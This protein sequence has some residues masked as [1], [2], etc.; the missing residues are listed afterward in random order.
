MMC[1]S[2][3]SNYYLRNFFIEVIEIKIKKSD[4]TN[5]DVYILPVKRYAIKVCS[6]LVRN[7]VDR[8]LV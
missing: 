4:E 1:I 7:Q 8:Y 6:G 5:D 2:Y 3:M